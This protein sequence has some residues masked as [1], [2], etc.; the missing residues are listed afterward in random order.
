MNPSE[1]TPNLTSQR[2]DLPLL[3][4]YEIESICVHLRDCLPTEPEYLF[5]RSMVLR[6]FAL[7]S[8]AMSVLG[9]DATRTTEELC[10]AVDGC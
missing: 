3:C 6:I 5:L 9:G 8:V 4:A 1:R 7:N 10:F 2:E